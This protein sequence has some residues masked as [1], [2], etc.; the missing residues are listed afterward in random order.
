M[1]N[2]DEA[3]FITAV[4]KKVNEGDSLMIKSQFTV[5]NYQF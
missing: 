1:F 5:V 3:R 4:V 2:T